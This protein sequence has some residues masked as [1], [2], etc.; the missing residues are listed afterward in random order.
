M[1]AH[2][3]PAFPAA[4]VIVLR[5]AG[6]G[7]ELLMVRRPERGAFG[8]LMVFPGGK[9]E[10]VDESPLSRRVV[11]SKSADLSSRSAA[12]R[13][14]AEETGLLVT[15][16]GVVT[17][18]DLRGE[19]LFRAVLE[20]GQLVKG[21]DLILVSRWLTPEISRRRFDTRFYLLSVDDAPDVRLDTEEL[22]GHA[23]TTPSEALARNADGEWP[24]ILPTI[25]H[26]R[27]L[28]CR[29]SMD[30]A[31]S[32]AVGADGLTVIAPTLTE[33][34]SLIPIYTAAVDS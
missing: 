12:L 20:A 15:T 6:T 32:S 11:R 21:D 28:S 7:F 10:P 29:T 17:S 25:S 31:R 5:P 26:L 27:W 23:W 14:L 16:E 8:G 9:V 34:G 1:P 30:D 33:D 4:T 2:P 3:A 13:E 24:M 18:P 19:A 22:T